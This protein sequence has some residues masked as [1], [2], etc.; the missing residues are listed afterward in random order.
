MNP[1]TDHDTAAPAAPKFHPANADGYFPDAEQIFVPMPA[2]NICHFL[3][4]HTPEGYIAGYKCFIRSPKNH[5]EKLPI[6]CGS[7]FE[8]REDAL[9]DAF[10]AA[11]KFFTGHKPALAHLQDWWETTAGSLAALAQ[12]DV[13][14]ENR[15]AANDLGSQ[16][17]ATSPSAE[18]KPEL[19]S[20]AL[21]PVVLPEEPAAP[22]EH[23]SRF[24]SIAVAEIEPGDNPRKVRTEISLEELTEAIRAQGELLQPI[25]VRDMGEQYAA[26][27]A[28]KKRYRLIFGEGRWLAHQRLQWEKIDAKIYTG[29]TAADAKAKALVENL[30][31]TDMNAMDEAEGFADLSTLGW[32]LKRMVEQTGK[33]EVTIRRALGLVKLP[34]EVRALVRSGELSARQARTLVGWVSPRGGDLGTDVDFVK[35]PEVCTI[36][37]QTAA[38]SACDI[39]SDKLAEGI[40][41]QA[42]PA[43]LA[44]KLLVE[45]P[46][47]YGGDVGIGNTFFRVGD[48]VYTFDAAAWKARKKDIDAEEKAILAAAKDKAAAK[49]ANKVSVPLVD[50]AK[51]DVQH[52]EL[53][54]EDERYADYLPDGAVTNGIDAAKREVFICVQPEALAKL[55]AAEKLALHD[56]LT[57]VFEAAHARATEK[58]AKLRKIGAR[59]MAF[60]AEVICPPNGYCVPITKLDF[61]LQKIRMPKDFFGPNAEVTRESLAKLDPVDLCRLLLQARLQISL[62]GWTY[63]DGTAEEAA[64]LRWILETP[65]L[66]LIQE[67]EKARGKLLARLSSELWP[68]TPSAPAPVAVPPAAKKPAKNSRKK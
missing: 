12:T 11:W 22:M 18:K 46:R 2:G 40:P 62:E 3:L 35:R 51:G 14:F 8:N 66:G 28:S 7:T 36:I 57:N 48:G 60:I 9:A 37:A 25:A 61:E 24:D 47:A 15:Q 26:T 13:Q 45:I 65:K 31:R 10:D 55:K 23:R 29:L 27:S 42:V 4:A 41:V 63:E 20:P 49:L 5:V 16:L 34:D 19:D 56:D 58:I 50:L 39:P 1:S 53:S 52:A 54:I 21:P 33:T 30:A 43:L 6:A 32:D 38:R 67:D 44:A 17:Y 59:E 64:M 68:K